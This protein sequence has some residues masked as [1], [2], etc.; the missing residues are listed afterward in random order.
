MLSCREFPGRDGAGEE[1]AL[2]GVTSEA[3]QV[4]GLFGGFDSLGGDFESEVVGHC[5]HGIEDREPLVPDDDH[6]DEGLVD[7]EDVHG[8][9]LEP[10][11]G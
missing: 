9:I 8:K 4:S 10:A 3:E 5:G 6:G 7:L 1:V 11:E 2:E